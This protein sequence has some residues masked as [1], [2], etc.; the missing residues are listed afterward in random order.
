MLIC[1]DSLYCRLMTSWPHLMKKL[2]Q[3]CL[4][5][6]VVESLVRWLR[7]WQIHRRRMWFS[8][9]NLGTKSWFE[10]DNKKTVLNY[11][12]VIWTLTSTRRIQTFTFPFRLFYDNMA[13]T[14]ISIGALSFT[15]AVPIKS[16][17]GQNE[18][19]L[20]LKLFAEYRQGTVRPT[21]KQYVKRVAYRV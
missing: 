9:F 4:L 2:C 16:S 8:S 20:L 3:I 7:C 5:I 21:L 13:A 6:T 17:Q 10:S 14:H 18:T 11:F 1:F 15:R 12:M 19:A